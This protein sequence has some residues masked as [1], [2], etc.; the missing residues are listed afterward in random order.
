MAMRKNYFIWLCTTFM[1]VLTGCSRDN[2]IEADSYD[3]EYQVKYYSQDPNLKKVQRRW[4]GDKEITLFP[5]E[6]PPYYLMV[7]WNEDEGKKA[8]DYITDKGDGV[9]TFRHD[10]DNDKNCA[11]IVCNKYIS[12]PYLYVSS[13]Y[14]ESGTFLLE[15]EYVRIVNR[16]I[17]KMKEGQS[18]EA[19]EKKYYH[20]LERDTTN[21]LKDMIIFNCSLKTS[22]EILHLTDEIHFRDDVEWAEPSMIA[23]IHYL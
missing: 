11:F 3:P 15:N 13:S 8:L 5:Q 23:P 19:I 10:Y 6:K 14:K 4:Y 7:M 12:C 20:V 18:V 2:E 17:L 22:Y 9:V 21:E 1:M 16:I